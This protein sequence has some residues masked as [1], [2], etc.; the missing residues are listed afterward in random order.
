MYSYTFLGA[1]APWQ[2]FATCKIHFA[3]KSCVLVYWQRYCMALQQQASA[4][5]CGVVQGMEL[6]N[7]RRGRHLYSAGRPS[8]W[9]SAHILLVFILCCSTFLLA[10]VCFCCVRFCFYDTKPRDWLGK[11]LQNDLFCV[12]WDVTS[13]GKVVTSSSAFWKLPMSSRR[14]SVW[15]S[16][17][18]ARPACL[19][20]SSRRRPLK[21]NSTPQ[22]NE[23]AWTRNWKWTPS[24]T[25]SERKRQQTF[26]TDEHILHLLVKIVLRSTTRNSWT[27]IWTGCKISW[28]FHVPRPTNFCKLQENSSM[29]FSVYQQDR[30][31]D[32][33]TEA[34]T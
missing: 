1:F 32:K 26:A 9:A 27:L 5:L 33:L 10:N 8:R 31:T 6:R 21:Q 20:T 29:T 3:S 15:A 19:L 22:H 2:N 11:R 7:F 23:P 4:K 34:K 17:L 30:Q 12:E 13:N 14:M 25:D 18:G 24:R 16:A 28:L